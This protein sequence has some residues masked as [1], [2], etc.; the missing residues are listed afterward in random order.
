MAQIAAEI[1]KSGRY[2]SDTVGLGIAGQFRQM[3]SLALR[4]NCPPASYY[5][6]RLYKA[7]RPG[8][9]SLM[10]VHHYEICNL[11]PKLNEGRGT[12]LLDDKRTFADEATAR[13][14]PVATPVVTF[15]EGRVGRWYVM[16]TTLPKRDLVM[17]AFALNSGARFERW[18]YEGNGR[19]S[20][21]SER[22]DE[23]QLLEHCAVRSHDHGCFLQE[24]LYNH[25]EIVPL[26]GNGLC[27]VRAVTCMSTE[28]VPNVLMACFR[29]PTN[30][31]LVDNF[32]SE[33]L[34]AAI[35]LA[36]GELGV[37]VGLAPTRGE[38]VRHPDNNAPIAGVRLPYW[39]DVISLVR[40]AQAGF[41]NIPFVG[42]DVVI[43]PTGPLLLEA[44]TTWGTELLQIPHRR[45]LGDTSFPSVFLA[46]L[47]ATARDC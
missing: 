16:P 4:Y 21:R 40:Q 7:V 27:T 44:N 19:W 33:G 39:S 29:M 2:V 11:L 35:Q 23:R 45:P 37:G 47:R 42:W 13:A 38:H 26:A 3:G 18:T 36:T 6:F 43:A 31:A 25:E 34:S 12:Q 22:L 30:G 9:A 24:R 41:P 5:K 17:K 46:H 1:R 8:T 28:S 20:F 15:E 10:H 32:S 14:L